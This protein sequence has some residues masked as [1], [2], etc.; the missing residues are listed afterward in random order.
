MVPFTPTR[1]ASSA[2]LTSAEDEA[3]LKTMR[4]LTAKLNPPTIEVSPASAL[5]SATYRN[6]SEEYEA[7]LQA[8]I[9]ITSKLNSIEEK[10]SCGGVWLLDKIADFLKACGNMCYRW[11]ILVRNKTSKMS[12]PCTIGFKKK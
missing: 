2:K 5:T 4:E 7:Q 3:Q 9:E 1:A 11:S 12:A 8:M 6:I 10:S